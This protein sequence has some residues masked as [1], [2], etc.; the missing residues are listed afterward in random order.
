MKKPLWRARL[1]TLDETFSAVP[2]AIFHYEIRLILTENISRSYEKLQRLRGRQVE[3]TSHYEALWLNG[4]SNHSYL[5]IPYGCGAGTVAH[6]VSHA[7]WAMLKYIGAEAENEVQAYCIG[8]IV[9]N[10][11]TALIDAEK[12]RAKRKATRIE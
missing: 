10:V 1:K 8:H 4:Y 12:K 11:T 6:E 3:E 9:R 2:L 7:V 5:I